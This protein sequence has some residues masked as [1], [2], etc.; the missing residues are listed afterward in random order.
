V[1]LPTFLLNADPVHAQ[2]VWR[3]KLLQ[4]LNLLLEDVSHLPAERDSTV[5]STEQGMTWRRA[6]LPSQLPYVA[7]AQGNSH[8]VSGQWPLEGFDGDRVL[9]VLSLVEVISLGVLQVSVEG[10]VVPLNL[11]DVFS[12]TNVDLLQ[13]CSPEGTRDTLGRAWGERTQCTGCQEVEHQLTLHHVHDFVQL[14][15]HPV[16]LALHT[17]SVDVDLPGDVFTLSGTWGEKRAEVGPLDEH[18]G[19]MW[20]AFV[21]V[22]TS[23][24]LSLAAAI[25]P[26]PGSSWGEVLTTSLR[27]RGS[28]KC[29]LTCNHLVQESPV[30]LQVLSVLPTTGLCLESLQESLLLLCLQQ[31]REPLGD[32][33]Q[34]LIHPDELLAN[35]VGSQEL[36]DPAGLAVFRHQFLGFPQHTEQLLQEF[37][38]VVGDVLWWL[39]PEDPHG[40]QQDLDALHE[41]LALVLTALHMLKLGVDDLGH[42]ED[43]LHDVHACSKGLGCWGC[44]LAA[45]GGAEPWSPIGDQPDA[46]LPRLPP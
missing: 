32:V 9:E 7:P 1:T 33:L 6:T 45:S 16:Y 18:A 19:L 21:M 14:A 35:T 22:S 10:E 17:L 13:A 24:R 4:G 44:G 15:L 46:A 2:D 31:E 8:W 20:L 12:F 38:F 23:L 30:I 26:K 29:T 36:L 11:S 41:A 39:S 40:L 42:G 28:A 43:P 5:R 3:L 37:L 25:K 34:A 27:E